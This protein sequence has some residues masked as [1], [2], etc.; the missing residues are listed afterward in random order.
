MQA[1]RLVAALSSSCDC[2]SAM[3]NC[4]IPP[5]QPEL[6][7][8]ANGTPRRDDCSR[9]CSGGQ[10]GAASSAPFAGEHPASCAAAAEQAFLS[11]FPKVRGLTAGCAVPAHFRSSDM[12][13]KS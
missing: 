3:A 2:C 4:S 12:K 7:S 6:Q 5:Q 11:V 13:V 8:L 1:V 10:A 9:S